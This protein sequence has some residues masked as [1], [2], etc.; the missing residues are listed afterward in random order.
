LGLF[1]YLTHPQVR[2]DP[3][4]PV[5]QWGLSETG[6]ARVMAFKSSPLLAETEII[7]SSGETKALETAAL[8]AGHWR[9]PLLV[10]E[11]AHENDRSATGFLPPPEFETVADAFFA[12]PHDS[13]RG[14]EPAADAQRRIAAV[15][16]AC[17][18]HL[19]RGDVLMVG[20]GGVG[21]LLYCHLAGL[22]ISRAHDQPPGGGGHLFSVDGTTNAVL[23]GWKPMEQCTP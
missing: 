15:F 18:R 1:R 4:V 19:L 22:A 8:I 13:V 10:R 5:P 11:D 20:H 21:T 2:I 14:W 9:K 6:R 7:L 3:A 12:S 23:H 17:R 16:D